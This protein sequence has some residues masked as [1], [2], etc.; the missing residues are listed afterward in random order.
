MPTK[1]DI[2]RYLRGEDSQGRQVRPPVIP[3][4]ATA[5]RND[6]RT[7]LAAQAM[8]DGSSSA[9]TAQGKYATTDAIARVLQGALGGYMDRK[10]QGKYR[11]DEDALLAVRGGR[12]QEGLAA[13]QQAAP[14]GGQQAAPVASQIAAA[15]QAPAPQSGPSRGGFSGPGGSPNP[16]RTCRRRTCRARHDG[17]PARRW[18]SP[19]FGTPG[20]GGG[21]VTTPT[22]KPGPVTPDPAAT[23]PFFNRGSPAATV[24]SALTGYFQSNFRR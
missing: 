8:A 7:Q 10:Q 6:P 5:Y 19:F 14:A 13:M 12:G 20:G 9:P 24:A 23:S 18:A 22:G 15:L 11:V 17:R 3:E 1:A 16:R 2:K 4:V 21:T